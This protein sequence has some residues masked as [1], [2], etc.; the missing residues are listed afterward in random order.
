MLAQRHITYTLITTTT[1]TT[2]TTTLSLTLSLSLSLSKNVTLTMTKL[3]GGKLDWRHDQSTWRRLTLATF[4]TTFSPE[5][6][7][8]A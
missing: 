5:E 3:S 6:E 2:T 7:A 8:N 4:A 1:T